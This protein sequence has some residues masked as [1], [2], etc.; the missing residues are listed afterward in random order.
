MFNFRK[1]LKMLLLLLLAAIATASR[2]DMPA[3]MQAMLDCRT[4]G[5]DLL[6]GCFSTLVDTDHNNILNMTEISTFLNM[7]GEATV[8]MQICDTNHDGSLTLDDWN[9]PDSC[10]HSQPIISRICRFCERAGWSSKKKK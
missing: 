2:R 8:I 7:T 9:A 1:S 4:M 3:D 6:L 5:R 10:V